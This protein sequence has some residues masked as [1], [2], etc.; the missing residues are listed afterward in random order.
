[1]NQYIK[2]KKKF[3]NHRCKLDE[4]HTNKFAKIHDP[5]CKLIFNINKI[6]HLQKNKFAKNLFAKKFAKS[7]QATIHAGC[8]LFHKFAHRPLY[9]NI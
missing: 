8:S 9:I 7:L 1:M 4:K 3:A 2:S 5:F 6:N